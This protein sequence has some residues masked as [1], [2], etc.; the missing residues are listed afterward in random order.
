MW[1]GFTE[2]IGNMKLLGMSHTAVSVSSIF[3]VKNLKLM[4]QIGTKSQVRH[5]KNVK[6]CGMFNVV[7]ILSYSK[8][9]I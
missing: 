3:T 8:E 9:T 2:R 6:C 4:S 1:L 7:I 5:A